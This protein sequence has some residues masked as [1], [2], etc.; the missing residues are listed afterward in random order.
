MYLWNGVYKCSTILGLHADPSKVRRWPHAGAMLGHHGPTL[1]RR[2]V[3]AT[4]LAGV[5]PQVYLPSLLCS[6]CATL[7]AL[8]CAQLNS[9]PTPLL[10][11]P[12]ERRAVKK[13]H[14]HPWKIT[15]V[16]WPLGPKLSLTGKVNSE[17]DSGARFVSPSYQARD[18]RSGIRG[19]S[20]F[21][22]DNVC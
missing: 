14:R 20:Y 9:P 17:E 18:V 4:C 1:R 13:A 2:G 8:A 11:P 7:P 12:L 22:L 6:V 19:A 16:H 3:S 15:S 5:T 10:S 21:S